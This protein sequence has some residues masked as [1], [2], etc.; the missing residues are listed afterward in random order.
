MVNLPTDLYP[1]SQVSMTVT[2]QTAE[3]ISLKN[4]PTVINFYPEKTSATINLQIN[5]A[6]LWTVGKAVVMR[7]TP[8]NA[9][10]YANY[11]DI[12]LNAVASSS[13]T[14]TVDIVTAPSGSGKKTFVFNVQCSEFGKF[15]Y[16]VSR[17]FTYNTTACTLTAAE[18][19]YWLEQSSIDGL[20]VT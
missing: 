6:T 16:H 8:N 9:N 3:G 10:T 7:I 12:T 13:N 2:L 5:D 15:I 17:K 4:N 14:P 11:A 20:R 19:K 1:M 18:M